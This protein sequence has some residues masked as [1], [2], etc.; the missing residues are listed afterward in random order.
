[1]KRRICVVVLGA[2]AT[3]MLSAGASNGLVKRYVGDSTRIR[4]QTTLRTIGFGAWGKGVSVASADTIETEKKKRVK[5]K[6]PVTP[7]T[8]KGEPRNGVRTSK[9]DDGFAS[10]VGGCL[11][12]FIFGIFLSD[13]DDDVETVTYDE[14]DTYVG[15]S[16]VGEEYVP[17]EPPASYELPYPAVVTPLSPYADELELWDGPGGGAAGGQVVAT[18]PAGTRVRVTDRSVYN[19]LTWVRVEDSASPETSG[20]I[21]QI[22]V[23]P[24]TTEPLVGTEV[25]DQ[26]PG[27]AQ[28]MGETKE[29]ETEAA[30]QQPG[31]ARHVAE[32]GWGMHFD[33]S[34]P[35]F[36]NKAIREEYKGNAVRLGVEARKFF[37]HSIHMDLSVGYAHA[38]GDP[39]YFYTTPTSVEQPVKSD[40][41]IWNFGVQVGQLIPVAG[42]TG[43]FAYDIGPSVFNVRESAD[44]EV[45]EQKVLRRTRTD[46]L[47]EW[48]IGGEAKIE[49]GWVLGRH[50][51]VS[52]HTRFSILPW[53]SNQEKSQTLDFLDE[54]VIYMFD[55][56]LSVGYLFF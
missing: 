55:F 39:Q 35:L 5:K 37:V 1:M 2:A 52:F 56:G 25:V 3:L 45:Y 31:L 15:E 9:K 4:H 26:E 22:E 12:D 20:W 34:Y 42:G 48:K 16:T 14:E 21:Q 18:L 13:D 29:V 27:S 7:D 28:Q 30:V 47:S 6:P 41:N 40:L 32:A 24:S 46:K 54:D 53:K 49:L 44:I 10:C 17:P 33:I 50:W 19:N 51:P 38:G 8:K 36:G 11:G 43:F 23:E